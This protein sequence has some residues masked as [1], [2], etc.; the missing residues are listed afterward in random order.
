LALLVLISPNKY[1]KAWALAATIIVGTLILWQHVHYSL[2][3]V[4]AP[5]ASFVSYK[6]ILFIHRESRYGLE[7]QGQ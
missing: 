7:L 3:V 5:L 2:D 6:V 1:V 4:F